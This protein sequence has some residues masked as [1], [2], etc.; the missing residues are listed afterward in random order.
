M[1]V[2]SMSVSEGECVSGDVAVGISDGS[3]ASV[4]AYT[5]KTT[6]LSESEEEK[7]CS[8]ARTSTNV[9]LDGN[10]K[11]NCTR[12]NGNLFLNTGANVSRTTIMDV[13]SINRRGLHTPLSKIASQSTDKG[14]I[15]TISNS[16]ANYLRMHTEARPP[17]VENNN[18]TCGTKHT[19]V[20]ENNLINV[21]KKFDAS[22]REGTGE[23]VNAESVSM[24]ANVTILVQD[25]PKGVFVAQETTDVDMDL[26]VAVNAIPIDSGL[27]QSKV[28]GVENIERTE[29]KNITQ[30]TFPEGVAVFPPTTINS[31]PAMEI[32]RESFD[33]LTKLAECN[34]YQS[35]VK[36]SGISSQQV[37]METKK[38]ID[39]AVEYNH[40]RR[41][42]NVTHACPVCDASLKPMDR[43][44]QQYHVN[45]CLDSSICKG[46][47]SATDEPGTEHDFANSQE[48]V[49]S[50]KDSSFLSSGV[51]HSK[52][53]EHIQLA[54]A[55]SESL[56]EN[57]DINVSKAWSA[58]KA[59]K[60]RRYSESKKKN[61]RASKP[62]S[63]RDRKALEVKAAKLDWEECR[64]TLFLLTA[65]PNSTVGS[66]T[67]VFLKGRERHIKGGEERLNANHSNA[68]EKTERNTKFN[69]NLQS[70]THMHI[71]DDTLTSNVTCANLDI[72][73]DARVHD[74]ICTP[75]RLNMCD[76]N[77]PV[78]R[79]M[80]SVER[81]N[82]RVRACDL[83]RQAEVGWFKNVSRPAKTTV[84]SCLGVSLDAVPHCEHMDESRNEKRAENKGWMGA[85][86]DAE[87]DED[88]PLSQVPYRSML[89]KTRTITNNTTGDHDTIKRHEPSMWD[90]ASCTHTA[91]HARESFYVDG[92]LSHSQ[93]CPT[94]EL[95][96]DDKY[97]VINTADETS[98]ADHMEQ[99]TALH[100][101]RNNIVEHDRV[102]A[103][104]NTATSVSTQERFMLFEEAIANQW[105][106]YCETVLSKEIKGK[107][108]DEINA[109]HKA[110]IVDLTESLG[111]LFELLGKSE[112]GVISDLNEVR[113]QQILCLPP[114]KIAPKQKPND[115]G[116][117]VI[118]TYNCP[119]ASG[120]TLMSTPTHTHMSTPTHT[121]MSIPAH[122][123][124]CDIINTNDGESRSSIT[125]STRVHTYIQAE[126]E[127]NVTACTSPHTPV[128]A[129][130]STEA[131]MNFSSDHASRDEIAVACLD[132]TDTSVVPT[133]THPLPTLN[134]HAVIINLAQD[135]TENV[136]GGKH[137]ATNVSVGMNVGIN[138]D[139]DMSMGEQVDS[140]GSSDTLEKQGSIY[141]HVSTFKHTTSA[142]NADMNIHIEDSPYIQSVHQ[143]EHADKSDSLKD[144]RTNPHALT[145][146]NASICKENEDSY[147]CFRRRTEI[148]VEC[149]TEQISNTIITCEDSSLLIDDTAF[150]TDRSCAAAE[151]TEGH[152]SLSL[153][154]NLD[155]GVGEGDKK[156]RKGGSGFD[157]CEDITHTVLPSKVGN[158]QAV[159]KQTATP[160]H[161]LIQSFTQECLQPRHTGTDTPHIP[162]TSRTPD[163]KNS[164]TPL[165]IHTSSDTERSTWWEFQT[166]S[167]LRS[168][169]KSKIDANN[170][171]REINESAE[172]LSDTAEIR[173][174][175]I[176]QHDSG[177]SVLRVGPE[178]SRTETH[179]K[180]LPFVLSDPPVLL[181]TETPHNP[182][183]KPTNAQCIHDK[184]SI[185]IGTIKSTPTAK[186]MTSSLFR[187]LSA[188]NKGAEK[189]NI[190]SCANV[191]FHDITVGCHGSTGKEASKKVSDRSGWWE[192]ETPSPLAHK[193]KSRSTN[194]ENVYVNTNGE[195][196]AGIN[197]NTSQNIVS[198][199]DGS[200]FVGWGVAAGMR[201]SNS[202]SVIAHDGYDAP[203]CM[204]RYTTSTPISKQST[205]QCDSTLLEAQHGC[206]ETPTTS[207]GSHSLSFDKNAANSSCVIANETNNTAQPGM[208]IIS[209]KYTVGESAQQIPTDAI[210]AGAARRSALSTTPATQR[211]IYAG[212]S[213][214]S[215]AIYT[216][217]SGRH[218]QD[219][220]TCECAQ[221]ISTCTSANQRSPSH[222]TTS[223]DTL[224]NINR[225]KTHG[226]RN[227]GCGC[228]PT[229]PSEMPE[230][231]SNSL[232]EVV[233]AEDKADRQAGY[234]IDDD[235]SR[236][237]LL[238]PVVV[239]STEQGRENTNSIYDARSTA[240]PATSRLRILER[241][242]HV[243]LPTNIHED[244]GNNNVPEADRRSPVL[245]RELLIIPSDS[246]D[247]EEVVVCSLRERL[248]NVHNVH[249]DRIMSST[250]STQ[251]S[252]STMDRDCGNVAM[253][254]YENVDVNVGL[255][256]GIGDGNDHEND[257]VT[258]GIRRTV[259]PVLSHQSSQQRK[260]ASNI[261][262]DSVLDSVNNHNLT[263]SRHPVVNTVVGSNSDED[264]GSGSDNQ[265]D[266]ETAIVFDMDD[267]NLVQTQTHLSSRSRPTTEEIFT[268]LRQH[269]LGNTELRVAMLEYRPF[270]FK[271]LH[272]EFAVEAKIPVSK[273]M[274]QDFLDSTAINYYFESDRN[275]KRQRVLKRK[276]KG[277]RKASV[278]TIQQSTQTGKHRRME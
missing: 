131:A 276:D 39:G 22:V 232:T 123:H 83:M 175:F 199:C 52:M 137:V 278:T 165:N 195:N 126:E 34:I 277:K 1:E 119:T 50:T 228:L 70:P 26:N 192:F 258:E 13:D 167:L 270:S 243:N 251:N 109:A 194:S 235:C 248:K 220:P 262:S 168:G 79:A 227:V 152:H 204:E 229:Q 105:K 99:N 17:R 76:K 171:V 54:L 216:S 77:K 108:V 207:H 156:F 225:F 260:D 92:I 59:R 68:A 67:T 180:H 110:S 61:K 73:K 173:K 101:Q 84:G 183:S 162:P 33:K 93:R 82:M 4:I 189:E 240:H 230:R 49:A 245:P 177:S 51:P 154:V 66:K 238:S 5:N 122:A 261:V 160:T 125:S 102:P 170:T 31:K 190:S 272:H 187:T 97:S 161:D 35:Q 247:E 209:H 200:A 259:A 144:Q 266:D 181:R 155:V 141:A 139:I 53:D 169:S 56:C 41:D 94:P 118:S 267:E 128:N 10:V 138:M 174:T 148:P 116:R 104:T 62:L 221:H 127:V 12:K 7:V 121:H 37:S 24:D 95:G 133:S 249:V 86:D 219:T 205:K 140:G 112:G 111:R 263:I 30:P 65:V 55:I 63:K 135:K 21:G 214:S 275:K 2:E 185:Q 269:F 15:T 98:K 246:S 236:I 14:T 89:S 57:S 72:R 85:S 114:S 250:M 42:E 223:R 106:A 176:N 164:H 96:E 237:G 11:Q 224:E 256:T 196:E 132:D 69:Q 257:L 242:L 159:R 271:D 107:N 44:A 134:K 244:D 136:E 58:Q 217:N 182:K 213:M 29:M 38:E 16:K 71:T 203:H 210:S 40:L 20:T 147:G 222:A 90:I 215:K 179:T 117:A 218:A 6:I 32:T 9:N 254:T 149:H 163:T 184:R 157:I 87:T 153:G 129:H 252:A 36:H 60:A 234:H 46:K 172:K 166:P 188:L 48:Y 265:S 273:K 193:T 115:M 143:L 81:Y 253:G 103:H 211:T 43:I 27:E 197:V 150:E 186:Y 239:E 208:A 113:R 28:V 74:A 158:T 124:K 130:A 18:K 25:V 3:T 45:Y 151:S 120:H 268:Q 78:F 198:S 75:T 80:D 206:I 178:A 212:R 264:V 201:E 146:T 19:L 274:L 100:S 233:M 202:L 145:R 64:K 226:C 47:S 142:R 88:N 191:G 241:S 91:G 8:N 255:G 23:L 231:I